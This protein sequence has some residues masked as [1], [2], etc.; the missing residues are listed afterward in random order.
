MSIEK[1]GKL[2]EIRG[3]KFNS[4]TWRASAEKTEIYIRAIWWD[5]TKENKHHQKEMRDLTAKEL[6]SSGW[7][8]VRT[9]TNSQSYYLDASFFIKHTPAEIKSYKKMEQNQKKRFE[10]F[11]NGK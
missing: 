7:K 4:Q 10:D 1:L 6:R 5:M 8:G 3:G 2:I 11:L 9:R